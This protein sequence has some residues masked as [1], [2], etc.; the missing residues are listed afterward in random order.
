MF[1]CEDKGDADLAI[2]LRC[3]S[4]HAKVLEGLILLKLLHLEG[5][6]FLPAS[7]IFLLVELYGFLWCVWYSAT[8]LI[9]RRMLEG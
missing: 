9:N 1:Y 4:T 3:F 5:H 2:S 8:K 7:I 6:G